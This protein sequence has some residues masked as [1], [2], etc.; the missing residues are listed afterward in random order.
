M[1][2]SY[3]SAHFYNEDD[4]TAAS[5]VLQDTMQSGLICTAG[6]PSQLNLSFFSPPYTLVVFAS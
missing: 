2:L 3:L 1:S 6:T 4:I 5:Q